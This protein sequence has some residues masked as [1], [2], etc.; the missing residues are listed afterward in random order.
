[1]PKEL[2]LIDLNLLSGSTETTRIAFGGYYDIVSG[3]YGEY[4][5]PVLYKESALWGEE[6]DK[7]FYGAAS[8][9]DEGLMTTSSAEVIILNRT[10]PVRLWPNYNHPI[11]AGTSGELFWQTIWLGGKYGTSSYDPIWTDAVFDD[12]SFDYSLP[13]SQQESITIDGGSE[14]TDVCQITYDYNRYLREYQTYIS[15]LESELLIPNMYLLKEYEQYLVDASTGASYVAAGDDATATEEAAISLSSSIINFVTRE[16]NA[17]TTFD[18]TYFDFP[19]TAFDSKEVA[20]GWN[21]LLLEND[22]ASQYLT[23]SLS[24]Y[25]LS[26]STRIE[27]S[28]VLQ[29]IMFDDEALDPE[30]TNPYNTIGDTLPNSS[31]TFTDDSDSTSTHGLTYKSKIPFYTTVNFNT[32]RGT[33]TDYADSIT[34]R[35]FSQ[36]FLKTLKEV[37]LEEIAVAPKTS[38]F[39]VESSYY[40]ASEDSGS[41]TYYDIQ[42][43]ENKTYRSVDWLKMLAYTHNNSISTTNNCY[44]A[45]G[46]T[47]DRNAVFDKIGAYRHSNAS[48]SLGVLNDTVGWL[49]NEDN[50]YAPNFWRQLENI[51]ADGSK[52]LGN[53]SKYRE[54]LAYRVEKVGGPPTGDSQTQNVLQNFWFFNP[55]D[56]SE[57][58]LYDSQVKY[59]SSYTYN[60]YAYVLV[61]GIKY[62]L[63]DLRLARP[64]SSWDAE[65]NYNCLQYYDPLTGEVADQLWA[66]WE[67]NPL[68]GS[69]IYATNALKRSAKSYRYLADF[70][71]NYEPNIKLIEVP[72]FSKT[73]RVLDNPPN[74]FDINPYQV[75]D[76]SQTIGFGIN[77]ETFYIVAED[78]AGMTYPTPISP[79]DESFKNAYLNGRDLLSGSYLELES[80]SKQRYFEAYRLDEKPAS[81]SDFAGNQI[82][83]IDLSI[84]SSKYNY[85]SADFR[86]K[87]KTNQKYYYLFRFVNEQGVPGQLSEIY[88]TELVDDGGYKYAVFNILFQSELG[89]E[90]YVNP[91]KPFKKLFQLQPNISQVL[92][93]S[94]EA[95]FDNLAS[96][97]IGN[98]SVGSATDSI[99]NQKFK[100]RMTSKKTGKKIDFNITYKVG[101][102][103]EA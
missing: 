23:S 18:G 87:I 29:N 13:Y 86:D 16:N 39:A 77:Y 76:N 55:S 69:N 66:A 19:S 90:V 24:L 43:T 54:T 102:G 44:F 67:D 40:K 52:R 100:L 61:V 84:P 81:I 14:F 11:L 88:E 75:N 3:T 51:S 20:L 9:T 96:E 48:S 53:S 30:S 15:D 78:I 80:V 62:N 46:A 26:S 82:A 71:V 12:H 34:N 73:L 42:E 36:K 93:D 83:T 92:L 31:V 37:F 63:S 35:N 50:F 94:S 56:I 68:S 33:A 98:I 28:N 74:S 10:V 32:E 91:F 89:E 60:I 25:P 101:P 22:F 95:D 1:M 38:T 17:L 8:T 6:E 97:E 49:N 85:S 21:S 41:I 2:K 45:G 58:N 59:G 7:L 72:M 79:T 103:D 5:S 99:W 65:S 57:I 70:N 47:F 4:L 64:I 27:I